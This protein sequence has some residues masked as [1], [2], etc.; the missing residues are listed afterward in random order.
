MPEAPDFPRDASVYQKLFEQTRI[1][2]WELDLSNNHVG[3]SK[4]FRELLGAPADMPASHAAFMSFIYPGDHEAMRRNDEALRANRGGTFLPFRVVRANGEVR[5]LQNVGQVVRDGEK[6]IGAVVDITERR[7]LEDILEAQKA[8]M[9]TAGKLSSL[10]EMAGG[11]AHEIN[12]PVAIIHG[13][14]ALLRKMAERGQVQPDDLRATAGVIEGTAD[15]IS[16]IIRALRAFARD[17]GRDPFE[18]V[19]VRALLEETAEFCRQRFLGHGVDFTLDEAPAELR[20]ECRPV[21]ISQVLL[22]LLNNAFDAVEHASTRKIHL[23]VQDRG[24]HVELSVSD[25][26]PGIPLEA[27]ERVFQP[28]FTTKEVGRGTGLGLSVAKGLVEAHQGKL[29]YETSEQ[30]TRFLVWLPKGR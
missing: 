14:A 29:T 24:R 15:R 26:G 1:G 30:G 9:V 6:L 13:H 5:W 11:L 27:R 12:N 19:S 7:A 2:T 8:Q 10:G 23:G 20:L 28:F 16:R 4:V 21:Q 17:A 22:N 18:Q 3:W 25:T